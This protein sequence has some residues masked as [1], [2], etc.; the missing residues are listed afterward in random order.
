MAPM[1][2]RTNVGAMWPISPPAP[3]QSTLLDE[4]AAWLK[5][6][7]LLWRS[8]APG[9]RLPRSLIEVCETVDV[10]S[11]VFNSCSVNFDFQV[12]VQAKKAH[13]AIATEDRGDRWVA[14]IF[15][16]LL[17]PFVGTGRMCSVGTVAWMAMEVGQQAMT[18]LL[19]ADEQLVRRRHIAGDT[20]H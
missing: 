7:I 17:K 3:M 18:K 15:Q 4:N 11:K 8:S 20:D 2:F 10:F 9:I 6:A 12:F 19:Q 1:P 13:V 16:T 14:G 5:P